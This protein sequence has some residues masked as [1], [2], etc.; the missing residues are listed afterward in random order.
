MN[1]LKHLKTDKIHVSCT[2]VGQNTLTIL[3]NISANVIKSK[4]WRISEFA[5][6]CHI[7]VYYLFIT[8]DIVVTAAHYNSI[9]PK[10]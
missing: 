5:H 10:M 3:S 1:Y 9:T 4:T 2:C 8:H 6:T 7:T